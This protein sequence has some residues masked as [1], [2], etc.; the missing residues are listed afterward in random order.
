MPEIYCSSN[1]DSTNMY[2]TVFFFPKD[3][4]IGS[5]LIQQNIQQ[6][7]SNISHSS[8]LRVDKM[9]RNDGSLLEV[10]R[11]RPTIIKTFKLS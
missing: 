5:H 4:E 2:V 10:A 1:Y 6:S 9:T 3:E 8:V 7:V 11:K